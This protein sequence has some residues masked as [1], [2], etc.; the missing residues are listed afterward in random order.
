MTLV[1]KIAQTHV[2]P[3]FM[4]GGPERARTSDA[5]S[6]NSTSHILKGYKVP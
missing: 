2:I 5:L 1:Y 6:R 4:Y 3:V